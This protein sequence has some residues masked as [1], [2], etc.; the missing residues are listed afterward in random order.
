MLPVHAPS[1]YSNR[2]ILWNAVEKIEKAKNAQLAREVRVALPVE[3]SLEQN[4]HLVQEYVNQN[5]I[6][7]GM[8]A[9]ICI[10]DKGD[11]N[12]HAHILLT[13]RPIEQDG[14][15]GAKSKMEY[16][17]D[18]KGKRIMLPS[19][20]PKTRKINTTD[21]DD[22]ANA[23]VWREAWADTV[24]LYLEKDGY[25]TRIDHR[26][27]ERQGLEQLPTIHLGA[28]THRMEQR[29]IETDRGNINRVTKATNQRLREFDERIAELQGWLDEENANTEPPTLADFIY[30][31]LSRQSQQGQAQH[32]RNQ[33]FIDDK[34]TNHILGF[35]KAKEI[36]DYAD[37]E[38]YLKN[39]MAQQREIVQNLK[40]IKA[41]LAEINDNLK[42]YEAHKKHKAQHEKY[43][44]D[45]ATQRPWKKK[46]FE[47][48]H[49]WIV[50]VY[51]ASKTYIDSLRNSKN[52]IP[53][54]AWGRERT[55]LS[56]ELRKLNSEYNTLKN[57]VDEVGKI[58]IKVYDILRKK[59]QRGTPVRVQGVER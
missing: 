14:S 45:L 52:Q 15:W 42:E 27:Y 6:S 44:S 26:S 59:R 38:S 56:A 50:G 30:D 8:C 17:L 34:T 25:E 57:E 18:K 7:R 35:L 4:I 3:L 5:F 36:A 32:G 47:Q 10:H 11:G 54:N 21:W 53:V 19:G 51:E 16:I 43:Q 49:G 31:T 1:E 22:R 40:P 39:L 2:A 55:K 46:T 41:K 20:R 37:L 58:R 13:M 29:G 9:D 23:E 28:A 24:N 48:E 12:P 33:I